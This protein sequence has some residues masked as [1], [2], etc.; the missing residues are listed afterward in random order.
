MDIADALG[1]NTGYRRHM[2]LVA[3]AF[4]VTE[5]NGVGDDH[6]LE[7]SIGK[8][9]T[10]RAQRRIVTISTSGRSTQYFTENLLFDISVLSK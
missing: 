5:R 7:G 3:L 2:Q 1:Q 6:F 4:A 9:L 10:G 8:A